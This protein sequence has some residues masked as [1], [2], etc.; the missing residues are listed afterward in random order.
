MPRPADPLRILGGTAKIERGT[1]PT[2]ELRDWPGRAA[3]ATRRGLQALTVWIVKYLGDPE[4]AE[5]LTENCQPSFRQVL[6]PS[7]S[8]HAGASGETTT[9]CTKLDRSTFTSMPKV[10]SSAPRSRK[11]ALS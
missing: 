5:V 1:E 11:S 3:L 2:G 6:R 4:S 8:C 7:S 10:C 9:A